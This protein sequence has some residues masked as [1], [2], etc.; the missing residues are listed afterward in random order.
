MLFRPK[1]LFIPDSTGAGQGSNGQQNVQNKT[2]QSNQQNSQV[3]D[4]T[5]NAGDDSETESEG[6]DFD[7]WFKKQPANVQSV[8]NSHVTGLKSALQTERQNSRDLEKQVRNLSKS[9]EKGSQLETDLNKLADQLSTS[10]K[11]ADFF[12]QAHNAGITNLRLAWTVA[13]QD[14]LF[15][16]R[17]NPD[18][19]AL[20]K[21][22]PEL[23]GR[24]KTSGTNRVPAN[25]GQTNESA[26][27]GD[28][29]AFIRRSSG[30]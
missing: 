5:D 11:R 24:A 19:T 4:E 23:F 3:N 15:D 27:G 17:G 22:Y 14:D 29:N 12:E 25:S 13:Q 26:T 8:I 16:R 20:R 18:F 28:M 7:G 6:V 21:N 10:D 9:A 30:R 1:F 2:A